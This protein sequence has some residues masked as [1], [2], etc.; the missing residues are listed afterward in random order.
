MSKK[1]PSWLDPGPWLPTAQRATSR[2]VRQALAAEQPAEHELAVLLSPAAEEALEEMAQRAQALTRRH[3]GRTVSLY[4]PLYLS[5]YCS[6][7]CVYCGFASD[8]PTPRRRLTPAEYIAEM[9]AIHK[10]GFEEI[11]L[12]TGERTPEAD[13]DYLRQAVAEAA[14]RFHL[15]TVEAFPMTETEYAGLVE[16]GAAGVTL[17]QETY[18][19][20]AYEQLHRW[21]PKRDYRDRLE[22]PERALR[23]GM[24]F[25]GLGALLGLADPLFDII[26]LYRHVRRL[27][28]AYWQAGISVSFPRVRPQRGD[29]QPA[30]PVSDRQLAQIICA[31]RL[32]LPDAPLVLS[33][34]ERAAFRDGMAG[35]GISKMSVASRTTVGGYGLPRMEAADAAQFE[36]NDHRAVGAFCAALRARGLE[37]VFK[38]WDRLY[39]PLREA[40]AS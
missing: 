32:C 18:D 8:R 33:T 4:I 24:R 11:L 23:S 3:F 13:W 27:Q 19:P 16:A 2:D 5:N 26:A 30:H 36:V 38:N 1:P 29:F 10:M 37:P 39:G 25:A 21:G 35:I 20:A 28:R 6:S 14:Q 40:A 34:R 15:V 7:G 9:T 17:Y 31:L 12:L 22:A